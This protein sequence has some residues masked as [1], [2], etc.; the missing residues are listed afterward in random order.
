MLIIYDIR[1]LF[2]ICIPPY[3]LIYFSN[4]Q[5][6]VSIML[7]NI[8]ISDNMIIIIP[9]G[10]SKEVTSIF[11]HKLQIE[12]SISLASYIEHTTSN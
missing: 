8:W 2:L 7:T 6:A 12:F 5:N 4:F 3:L 11:A 1:V 9:Q 10:I